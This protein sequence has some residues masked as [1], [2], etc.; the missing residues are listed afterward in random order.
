MV[1]GLSGLHRCEV[2]GF[3]FE[4]PLRG[5]VRVADEHHGRLVSQADRLLLHCLLV[6]V[7]EDPCE[8][9]EQW[10]HEGNPAYEIPG[11]AEIDPAFLFGE[12]RHDGPHRHPD[13]TALQQFEPLVGEDKINRRCQIS[14]GHQTEEFVRGAIARWRVGRHPESTRNRLV[15]LSLF[16]AAAGAPPIWTL[17]DEGT[18]GRIQQPDDAIVNGTLQG[19]RVMNHPIRGRG[20]RQRQHVRD[21]L[22][23]LLRVGN[24]HPYVAIPFTAGV[25]GDTNFVDLNG[26]VLDQRR[27][28]PATACLIELPTMIGTF[29]TVAFHFA[30]GQWHPTMGTNVAHGCDGAL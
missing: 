5:R 22:V 11:C 30:E 25:G 10:S 8:E 1:E 2:R 26:G 24:E 6:L 12:R 20:K 14:S 16:M 15:R 18:V 4:V 17:M 13:D 7:E 23:R 3:E 9:P 27:N 19:G 21:G 29:D 28:F